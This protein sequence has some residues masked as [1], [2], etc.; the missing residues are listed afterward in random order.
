MDVYLLYPMFIMVLLTLLVG[1]IAVSVRIKSVKKGE[2]KPKYFRLMGGQELPDVVTK[3][4][5]NFNNQF[6]VPTLFYVVCTLYI[7]LGIESSLA[8]ALA[9][10]FVIFRVAH[11]YIHITYNHVV[12]RMLTFFASFFCVIA[13]WVTLLVEM[14]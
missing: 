5:R 9:W 3:T 11:A 6:E 2:I 13:L 4:T 14:M 10:L 1:F 7:S 8:L 12:H